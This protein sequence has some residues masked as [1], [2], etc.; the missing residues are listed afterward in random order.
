MLRSLDN[1]TTTKHATAAELRDM[2]A[3]SLEI[4]G[5]NHIARDNE[6]CRLFGASSIEPLSPIMRYGWERPND[7]NICD[8]V[9][10]LLER[11]P[12]LSLVELGS[13]TTWGGRDQNF[14]VPGLSRVLKHAFQN[15][16]HITVTDREIGYDLFIRDAHGR[17]MRGEFRDDRPPKGMSVSPLGPGQTVIP[18]SGEQLRAAR[19]ADPTLSGVL[20]QL[21]GAHN[22]DPEHPEVAIFVRPRVDGEIEAIMYGVRALSGVNYLS[23]I[24]DLRKHEHFSRFDFIFARHLCPVLYPS[25][26][27]HLKDTLPEALQ[28]C[29]R[30]SYVQFDQARMHGKDETDL[31]FQHHEYFP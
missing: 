16:V 14:G 13:G 2:L 18:T 11:S 28:S 9:I 4:L 27:Q 29:A 30:H 24:E 7:Q 12:R 17:L 1:P 15:R 3:E 31:V 5:R 8:I 10:N 21:A 25:R 20:F 6:M 22:F 19:E 23:L 26:I